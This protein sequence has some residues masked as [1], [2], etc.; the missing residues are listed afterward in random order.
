MIQAG[1]E[2]EQRFHYRELVL[3]AASAGEEGEE[4][5][6]DQRSQR[7]IMRERGAQFGTSPA[8]TSALNRSAGTWCSR[9]SICAWSCVQP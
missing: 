9:V 7:G 4:R 6:V 1:A 3:F 5:L 2:L 8:S